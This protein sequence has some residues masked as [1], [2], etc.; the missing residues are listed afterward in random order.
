MLLLVYMMYTSV[1]KFK[2]EISVNRIITIA[3]SLSR[4]IGFNI[5]LEGVVWSIQNHHPI[6]WHCHY[7]FVYD[8]HVKG[9]KDVPD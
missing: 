9:L 1:I 6:L 3:S 8:E 5:V 7:S 4:R 2:F